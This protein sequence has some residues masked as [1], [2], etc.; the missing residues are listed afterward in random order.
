VERGDDP[1]GVVRDAAQNTPMLT[2]PRE[3]Q[4]FF[5]H[6]GGMVDSPDE[7]PLAYIRSRRELAGANKKR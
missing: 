6:T 4:A 1:M 3:R 5:T 7:D 2:V